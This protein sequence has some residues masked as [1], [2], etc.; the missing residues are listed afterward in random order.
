MQGLKPS[1]CH[2]PAPAEPGMSGVLKTLGLEISGESADYVQNKSQFHL[3]T[4]LT[5][6]RHPNTWNLSFSA[7]R[8]VAA[9]LE[10]VLSVDDDLEQKLAS[11]AASDDI[12]VIRSMAD[13]VTSA[14]REGHRVYIYG[15]GATGRLAKV[16]E[17]ALWRPFWAKVEE[18]CQPSPP[19]LTAF[20]AAV[21]GE[22]TGGDRALVSSLEGFED[23]QLLGALQLKDHGISKDDVV[24]CV[25][26]GGETSSVIG[27]AL[28]AR[29]LH[30]DAA[31]SK[32]HV[33]FVYNNPDEVL[34]PF[35]R[36]RSV[37]EETGITRL[38]LSTG[39]QAVSG[40]TRMQATTI[41]TFVIGLALETAAARLVEEKLGREKLASLGFSPE[42]ELSTSLTRDFKQ[43][44]AAV[45]A[46][47]P[48]LSEL[49]RL[50][51]DA[52]SAGH[53]AA[54]AAGALLCTV[55]T[56]CTERSPTFRLHPLDRVDAEDPQCWFHV[57][58]LGAADSTTAW[59]RLLGRSFRGLDPSVYQKP[60]D[61][62]VSDP[63]LHKAALTSLARAGFEQAE[64]YDFSCSRDNLARA[65]LQPSD[66]T[67]VVAMGKEIEEHR[68][69]AF[70]DACASSGHTVFI[71]VGD[72]GSP[73]PPNGSIV[74]VHLPAAGD[75]LGLRRHVAAKILLNAHSTTLMARL[76]RT[77]GNTMTNVSP[78][79]LKLF[80]RATFL[81]QSHVNDVLAHAT[82]ATSRTPI[83][84]AEANAVLF[85]AISWVQSQK[86]V[87][88]AEVA[89]SIIRLVEAL[90]TSAAVPFERAMEILTTIG[91]AEFLREHNPALDA[92]P[93]PTAKRAR[94]AEA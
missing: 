45:N 93:E 15:C 89:L 28:A 17:S 60:L 1:T 8:N 81:I 57:F 68:S 30:A 53:R 76:G 12:S 71:V 16:A 37:F 4:L 83:T 9:A 36:S 80:G 19:W 29:A 40:S 26:E 43:L 49:T 67:V 69:S 33:Y 58:V 41:E 2:D 31:A 18:K 34:R 11:I 61:S 62:G 70:M 3:H 22:M 25:T 55:F 23:L 5:E 90:R 46:A 79:N 10:A 84:F 94:L 92:M 14:V 35:G 48:A 85:D 75:P 54:Y 32:S 20:R 86:V 72:E 52:Y 56:D 73:A 51:S 65:K 78:S 13:A 7:S 39:P 87:Q 66:L 91:L 74:H 64:V 88:T 42:L 77:V 47:I 63:Y 6:Q 59:T 82:W 24:I 38:N 50:E 27:T 44:R 21:V